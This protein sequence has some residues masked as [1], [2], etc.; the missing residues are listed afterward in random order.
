MINDPLEVCLKNLK[1]SSR[2]PDEID[3]RLEERIMELSTSLRMKKRRSRRF[4]STMAL[5]LITGTG[6]VAFGGDS[7]VMNYIAPS[8]EKD[9]EGNPVPYDFNWGHWLHRAHDHLWDHFHGNDAKGG[10]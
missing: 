10:T 3:G 4:I 2:E 8:D 9:A 5:L 6:F 7:A 1:S